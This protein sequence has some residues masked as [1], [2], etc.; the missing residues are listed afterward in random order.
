MAAVTI[1]SD[2]GAQKNKGKK[3]KKLE[4][5]KRSKDLHTH[6]TEKNSKWPTMLEIREK[7]N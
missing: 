6:A 5:E 3:K 1:C 7:K 4:R 2:F